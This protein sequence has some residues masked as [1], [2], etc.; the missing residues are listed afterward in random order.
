MQR[1]VGEVGEPTA[2]FVA[3]RTKF[4]VGQSES[5]QPAVVE[6][7]V[8]MPVRDCL[9]VFYDAIVL[10]HPLESAVHGIPRPLPAKLPLERAHD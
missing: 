3:D 8:D 10:E 4:R 5:R 9:I 6:Q 1:R 2:Q 7:A